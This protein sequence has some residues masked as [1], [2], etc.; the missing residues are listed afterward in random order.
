MKRVLGFLLG[1][2]CLFSTKA[3]DWALSPNYDFSHTYT[4]AVVSAEGAVPEAVYNAL[5]MEL[6][7]VGNLRVLERGK[8]AEVLKEQELGTSGVVD[9]SKAPEIG[10]L[11]GADLVCLAN[12]DK[13][14]LVV[15]LVDSETGEVLYVGQGAAPDVKGAAEKALE[16]LVKARK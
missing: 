5:A 12:Y 2:G 9:P 1:L 3:Q 16:P 4:V 10:K 7:K 14:F 11:V 13:G 6:L 8:V 15:K